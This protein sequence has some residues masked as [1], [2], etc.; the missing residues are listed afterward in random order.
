MKKVFW[1]YLISTESFSYFTSQRNQNS[2]ITLGINYQFEVSILYYDQTKPRIYDFVCKPLLVLFCRS[3]VLLMKQLWKTTFKLW[4]KIFF[5]ILFCIPKHWIFKT[6]LFFWAH[7]S[8]RGVDY[9]TRLV[10]ITI[11]KYIFK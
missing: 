2:Q 4:K 11:N 1:C 8:L 5:A 7:F 10:Q 3:S 6:L 9:K